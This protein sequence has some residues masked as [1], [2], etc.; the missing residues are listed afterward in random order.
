MFKQ[1][2]STMDDRVAWLLIEYIY[3][4]THCVYH[5]IA[6]CRFFGARAILSRPAVSAKKGGVAQQGCFEGGG[7]Q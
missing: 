5:Q 3:N 7:G 4:L 2:D 6:F 1:W